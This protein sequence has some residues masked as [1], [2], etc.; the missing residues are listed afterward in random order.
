MKRHVRLTP[1]RNWCTACW[2]TNATRV[3][4]RNA[5]D[6]G[7]QASLQSYRGNVSRELRRIASKALVDVELE[8]VCPFKL[9]RAFERI[10]DRF[11]TSHPKAVH[12]IVQFSYTI[13][14][15]T[16]LYFSR[17]RNG[18]AGQF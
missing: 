9:L 12:Q 7:R 18:R 11:E 13:E 8:S 5:S 17:V 2:S 16:N 1:G 4:W 14:R 3:C 15:A 6:G 10:M